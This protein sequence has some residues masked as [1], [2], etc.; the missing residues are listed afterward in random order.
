MD[1]AAE[2]RT[3]QT[4]V[5][6]TLHQNSNCI[7]SATGNKNGLQNVAE[8]IRFNSQG[9]CEL[10]VLEVLLQDYKCIHLCSIFIN[11][12]PANETLSFLYKII[13]PLL[14]YDCVDIRQDVYHFSPEL[15]EKLVV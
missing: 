9:I 11:C 4:R 14:L 5:G 2:A 6:A 12:F 15:P 3:W 1:S 13:L 8:K 7:A 10:L